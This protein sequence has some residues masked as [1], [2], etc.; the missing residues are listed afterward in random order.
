M[1]TLSAGADLLVKMRLFCRQYFL[2]WFSLE[3]LR[4]QSSTCLERVLHEQLHKLTFQIQ[5]YTVSELP[6]EVIIL[7][8]LQTSTQQRYAVSVIYKDWNAAYHTDCRVS[9]VADQ[10]DQRETVQQM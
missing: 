7:L 3:C 10:C 8:W 1:R 6:T 2:Q 9:K 5:Y 4:T